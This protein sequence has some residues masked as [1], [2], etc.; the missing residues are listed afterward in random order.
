MF[1]PRM[2]LT[3]LAGALLLAGCGEDPRYL[4]GPTAIEVIPD[5]EMNTASA[6]LTLPIQIE[7]DQARMRRQNLA[8]ELGLAFEDVPYVKLDDIAVELE[9]S[10]KNLDPDE[11]QARV[12]L[13]GG[14]E[15][16]FYVPLDFV[17]DED[18]DPTPP[19]LAGDIPIPLAGNG[20]VDGL[21]REDRINEAS[22][23]LELITRG[24]ISPFAT[25]LQ[26]DEDTD[27]L[28][29][30]AGTKIPR[31]AFA[32]IVRFDLTFQSTTHMVMEYTVRVRDHRGILHDD[33]LDAPA[34]ELTAFEPVEFVP[35]A[36]PPDALR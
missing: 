19:P 13:N 22:I 35:P 9:F 23:D 26:V 10:I 34:G 2:I 5:G 33:L 1:H 16:F 25:M 31:A 24:A 4:Q 12:F 27:E 36:P 18:E 7:N 21:F 6:T 29:N 32:H 8:T 17:L 30:P 20:R 3:G 11:G 14:N 28:T 15:L